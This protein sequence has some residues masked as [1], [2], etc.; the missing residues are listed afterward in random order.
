MLTLKLKLKLKFKD[1]KTYKK[2]SKKKEKKNLNSFKEV[3]SLLLQLRNSILRLSLLNF[4]LIKVINITKL[5]TLTIKIAKI[6][7]K[8]IIIF[9]LTNKNNNTKNY[10]YIKVSIDL[11]YRINYCSTILIKVF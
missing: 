5:H 1:N 6:F 11:Q 4:K 2:Q 10:L 8:T 7:L 9:I 3:F